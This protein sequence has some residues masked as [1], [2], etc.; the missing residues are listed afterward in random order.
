MTSLKPFFSILIIIISLFI[1]VFAHMEERRMGYEF[2]KQ[3]HAQ[4]ELIENKRLKTIQFAKMTRPQQIEKLAFDKLTLKKLQ[5]NQII[6]LTG[7]QIMD[8]KMDVDVDVKK[9]GT[10]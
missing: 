1:V 9:I 6:H 10:N 7:N 5:S 2:L 4:K 8:P 3:S